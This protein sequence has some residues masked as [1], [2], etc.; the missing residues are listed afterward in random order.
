VILRPLALLALLAAPLGCALP[1]VSANTFLPAGDLHPGDL[2]AAASLEVGRVLVAPAD[3]LLDPTKAPAGA[4]KWEVSTWVASDLSFYWALHE[5]VVVEAQLK[6]TNPIEPFEPIPIGGALGAR[7]RLVGHPGA[8]GW[9]MELGPRL[10][11]LR[12]T[13][14]LVQTAGTLQQTDRWTYRALGGELPLVITD[15]LSPVLALTVS[16]FLRAYYLRAWHDLIADDGKTTT[17]YLQWTP[18]IS[19]GLGISAAMKLGPIEI[20]PGLAVEVGT[21]PGPNAPTQLLFEPGVALGL[22]W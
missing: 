5:R 18:V 10:V 21:R 11:G 9:A 14:E 7:I 19:A 6:L 16:P 17:T 13:E 8:T 20:A 12:V 3:L 22:T 1:V 2:R 4:S 15:R